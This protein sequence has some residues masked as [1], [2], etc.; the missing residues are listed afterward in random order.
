MEEITQRAGNFKPFGVFL[1]MLSSAF[2]GDV[3]SVTIDILTPQDLESM[4]VSTSGTNRRSLSPKSSTLPPK[5]YLILTYQGE[6]DQVHYPFALAYHDVEDIGELKRT[7]VRLRDE[8]EHLRRSSAQIDPV[9]LHELESVLAKAQRERDA[10]ARDLNEFSIENTKLRELVD[11][12]KLDNHTLRVK[13]DRIESSKRTSSTSRPTK[14]PV[15]VSSPIRPRRHPPTIPSPRTYNNFS[16][17]STVRTSRSPVSRPLR[18]SPVRPLSPHPSTTALSE[19]DARLQA[20]QNFLRNQ[21][22]RK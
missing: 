5:R 15:H 21:K 9:S 1:R 12:L 17:S 10:F 14:P 11:S 7:I 6:F 19:V 20:L 4:R 13:L 22:N 8:L 16:P 3:A 18:N 2:D